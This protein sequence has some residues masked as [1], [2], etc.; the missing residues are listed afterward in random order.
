LA[1]SSETFIFTICFSIS[2][3]CFC[4]FSVTVVRLME[5][6]GWRERRSACAVESYRDAQL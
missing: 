2:S 3:N 5:T 6:L 4:V 1:S